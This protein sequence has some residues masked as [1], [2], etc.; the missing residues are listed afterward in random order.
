MVLRSFA[1]LPIRRQ[2]C[3]EGLIQKNLIFIIFW[4][5][6]SQK[7]SIC[8]NL[9]MIEIKPSS[10]GSYC[11]LFS[12]N[13]IKSITVALK[14]YKIIKKIIPQLKSIIN[15]P[16]RRPQHNLPHFL[17]QLF[18]QLIEYYLTHAYFHFCFL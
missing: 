3:S 6:Q 12:F 2:W 7:F 18:S 16:Q 4:K 11:Y 9:Y 5:I 17:C 14:K 10:E 13:T 1:G 8:R 15:S